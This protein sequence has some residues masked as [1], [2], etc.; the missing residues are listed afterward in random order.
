MLS[1]PDFETI[2]DLEIDVSRNRANVFTLTPP[3]FSFYNTDKNIFCPGYK[4]IQR[5]ASSSTII[6]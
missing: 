5:V 6:V 2:I 3:S 4:G 1:K